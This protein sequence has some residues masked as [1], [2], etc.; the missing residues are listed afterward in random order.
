MFEQL[1]KDGRVFEGI[2][3]EHLKQYAEAGL[4]TLVV[5]YRELD[6]KEFQS[7]EQEFLNAQASVTA[8]RDALVDVAAQ[9]IERDLILLGVTAVEDKLQKG[10][11]ECIDK[12]A[13]AGI[14]IW[15]LTGDKMETA[16]NIGYA[17]SLLRPDMRQIIIT[18]DSQDI[19]DLENRGNK[20]TIAKASHDSITK[21]IREGMSQVSSSRGTTA[22]FG[23]II[24]GKSLSFALDKKLEKSFLELAINCASVICCRSTPK[25]KALV[26]ALPYSFIFREIFS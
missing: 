25:Q 17:C 26:G 2:T 19:L 10:V 4:R 12:L 14:K 13:K 21:Q 15:V 3:R 1:S 24:D 9:K 6:E 5:A 20:E 7:W 16:I 8:D 11:P 22:S 23:L 18:L